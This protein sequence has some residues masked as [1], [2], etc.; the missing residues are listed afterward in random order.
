MPEDPAK[1]PGIC[2]QRSDPKIA[3][4]GQNV[5]TDFGQN[6]PL[7]GS[8]LSFLA[9]SVRILD[10]TVVPTVVVHTKYHT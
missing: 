3:I 5:R 2:C 10:L 1:D 6:H 8:F 9:C 7:Y 4:L